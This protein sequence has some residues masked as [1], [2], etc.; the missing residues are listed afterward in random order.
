MFSGEGFIYVAS[1]SPSS[2]ALGKLFPHDRIL[3]VNDVDCSQG[4]LRMVTEAIRS[5]LPVARV[6]VK[7]NRCMR[8]DSRNTT[9]EQVTKWIHTARLAP[10]CHG[11]SLKMGVYINRIS[12][13]SLAARDKSLTV[14]DRVLRVSMIFVFNGLND[15]P[16][17]RRSQHF[18]KIITV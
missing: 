10:G 1:V 11:L 12:E 9:G 5:S 17:F 8:N 16:K 15:I 7:R 4:S 13:G 2:S 3:R 6:L 14:G 18:F